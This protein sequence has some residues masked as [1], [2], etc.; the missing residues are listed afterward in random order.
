MLRFKK[1][2]MRR[3]LLV[4]ILLTLIAAC[5][6]KFLTAEPA[7]DVMVKLA[8]LTGLLSDKE[9]MLQTPIMG[10]QSADDYYLLFDYY[11][12]LKPCDRNLYTW[13][14][15]IYSGQTNIPDWDIPYKQVYNCN[16]VLEEL[17]AIV[18]NATN[19]QQY[20]EL[21]GRA[22]FMRAYAFHNVAQ[23]F[24]KVYDDNKADKDD[25]IVMPMLPD[26]TTVPPRS[27]MKESYQRII[28]DLFRAAK[29]LPV[30]V[31]A[32]SHHIPNKPAAFALLARVFLSMLDYDKALIYADSTLA[33]SSALLDFNKLNFA[34]KFPVNGINQEMLY[35]SWMISS[36]NV[37][38]GRIVPN[39]IVD[40]M[41]YKS[42]ENNDLRK[43]AFFMMSAGRPIFKANYTG[44]SFA[45]SG[46]A[47]DEIILIRA[48][49]RARKNNIQGA[50]ADVNY[51]KKNRFKEN[52]FNAY[53]AGNMAEAL[54]IIWKERRK[55]LVFRG[56]RWADLRRLNKEHPSITLSR[57]VN[58]DVYK[59][60]PSSNK[61]VL[62]IPDDV[63]KGTSISQN[64][65]D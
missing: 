63:I 49:C 36:S 7:G 32:D 10:E 29:I 52:A 2:E 8:D 26:I 62:P 17:S 55:E 38:Q 9:I 24:A 28:T 11:N 1:N 21:Y 35:M 61:Y 51:L 58:S 19:K 48:E 56:L 33:Y 40:S 53:T 22:L 4:M 16:I 27:T 14:R 37:I 12:M 64:V 54:N 42:Y 41:L 43:D 45:F 30:T 13:E 50:M 20:D 6:R 46:L 44:K 15:D 31:P 3:F 65:R 18:P 34:N 23:V 5:T 60:P 47:L 39:C 25:G 59:L 57:N